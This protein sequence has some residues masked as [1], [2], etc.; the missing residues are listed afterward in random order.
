MNT[1]LELGCEEIPARFMPGLL[2]DLK[3]KAEEKL[4]RE[5]ISFG[6]VE[7]IGTGRRLV[8][9]I[10][11]IAARQEDLSEEIKGP[12]ADIAFGK[13]G[14]PGPAAIGFARTQGV[15]VGQL[16]VKPAGP[17]NY[18]FARI[19][20]KGKPVEKVL[21][22]LFPEIITALYL[23]LSM[24]WGSLDLK[25]IRP[26]HSILA[27]CGKKVV[28][29][30]LAGIRSGNKTFPH[31]YKSVGTGLVPVRGQPQGLSL[32][33][34]KKILL[35]LGVVVDQNERK[36][37]IRRQVEAAAAKAGAKALISDELLSEVT[38][39]VENPV[40]YSGKFNPDF[41]AVPQEV[42]ITSMQKNQKYF[43]LVNGS[44]K[45]Q[46]RFVV[47]TDGC[48]DPRVVEGNEKVLSARLSDARFFF[49]EDSKQPLKL[50]IGD[51]EK[52]SF[53]EKLG[54]VY[55]KVERM[56]RLVDYI[57]K[58]IGL[59]EKGIKAAHRIAELSKAD[60][61]TK[62]VYEFP[63]LQGVMGREYARQ[64]GEDPKVA[65]GI[66]EHYLPRFAEDELPQ[67]LEGMTV[68]IADRI[69]SMVGAFSVGSIP[70]GSEDPY[71]IRRAA[72]G[73]IRIVLEKK[74]EL[75]LD[76]VL[77]HAYKLYEP[78]FLGYLFGQGETGYQD[79]PRIKKEILQFIA[80]RLRP[81]LL[82]QGIRYDVADAALYD[83][84]DILDVR[85][86]AF[87][88][89][90]LIAEK[91][92]AG[93]V[94]SA[95]RLYRIAGQAPRQQVLEHD[96]A[97]AEEKSLYDLYLKVNWEV[98]DKVKKGDWAAAARELARLTDPIETFFDKILV[99]HKDER[100]KL[101]RLALLKSL[102]QDYLSVADFRKIVL[103]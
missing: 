98:A 38:F 48:N 33:L 81:Q 61:T 58:R 66:Y 2:A 69:D 85:D 101:N 26:I 10:E 54:T 17:K 94:A 86:K 14:K 35:K 96:L 32:Q 16:V 43:P 47:V 79:F 84:N 28:K 50:R 72:N 11:N 1:L 93:V 82:E 15:E 91:W 83:L 7:T 30:E 39:L 8:L 65:Q 24:R 70:T 68:A 99:M 56:G 12:P 44:G 19:V 60:L 40:V 80:G 31:R 21:E 71:G 64:S 76:E 73:I 100:L 52:V 5:R 29:F 102:E 53:F 57:G 13:D 88:L 62:M 75:F 27:L 90:P 97:E 37:M 89:N 22:T 23:P 34:Y 3:A 95:D 63:E 59:D 25:F 20:K 55:H 9:S 77:E 18:V 6:K 92:F 51:L 87:A 36:E 74:V 4:R 103:H 49:E 41:L 67:S 42:L 78:V 46:A 45:L